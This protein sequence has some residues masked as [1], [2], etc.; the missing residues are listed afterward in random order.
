MTLEAEVQEIVD[1]RAIMELKY[2]Y[3]WAVDANDV[4]A[5]ATLFTEDGVLSARRFS[6][7]EPYLRREGRDELREL[8]RER[9]ETLNR[10][11]GQHRPYNP[12]ITIDGDDAEGKW[13]M[14]AIAKEG[15]GTFEFEFGEYH[16]TYRRVDGDWKIADSL[17]QYLE[18]EPELVR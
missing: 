13:Y 16:E 3:C 1:Y 12:I 6:E 15:D 18:V 9:Q 11:L 7:P 4:D 14:T 8:V 5:F 2:R 17:V 10:T